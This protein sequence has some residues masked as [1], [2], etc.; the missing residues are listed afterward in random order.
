MV[1]DRFF[2]TQSTLY[3]VLSILTKDYGKIY[4]LRASGECPISLSLDGIHCTSCPTQ[5]RGHQMSDI[6]HRT[7]L[8]NYQYAQRD[9]PLTVDGWRVTVDGWCVTGDGC[10]VTD[11]GWRGRVTDEGFKNFRYSSIFPRIIEN[12]R[13]QLP[14]FVK[15]IIFVFTIFRKSMTSPLQYNNFSKS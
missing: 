15:A 9:G 7:A 10:R 4:S 6:R 12:Q 3:E 1:W 5:I 2:L 11:D 14:F 8:S 13:K